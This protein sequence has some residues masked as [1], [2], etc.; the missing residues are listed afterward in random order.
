MIPKGDKATIARIIDEEKEEIE[1]RKMI[2]KHKKATKN[3][4]LTDYPVKFNGKKD[5][6]KTVFFCKTPERGN[7]CVE[8][9]VSKNK[10]YWT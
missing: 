7:K 9:Y 5:L 10:K 8:E 2:K 6:N 3:V 4:V 1:G